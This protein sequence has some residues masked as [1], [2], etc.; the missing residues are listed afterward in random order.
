MGDEID[1]PDGE[2]I[3]IGGKIPPARIMTVELCYSDAEQKEH[4]LVYSKVIKGLTKS[5]D[6]DSLPSTLS[7]TQLFGRGPVNPGKLRRL[8]ALAFHGKLD[9][10]LSLEGISNK[11]IEHITDID[12]EGN[13][14]FELFWQLT[15]DGQ[16]NA[17]PR[18]RFDRARYLLCQSPR[19]KYLLKIFLAEGLT[20]SSAKPRF[21][22][23]CNW[24][25]TVWLV[26]MLLHALSLEFTS[27]SS[28]MGVA[29]RSE[30]I[31][32]FNDP[33]N[34]C[35]VFITTYTLGA[36]GLNLQNSCSRLVLME[37]AINYNRVFHAIGR[38][39]RLGQKEPQKIW[40]LFQDSTI[41]RWMEWR[42]LTKVRE[43]IAA[44][45]REAFE[46]ILKHRQEKRARDGISM[47]AKDEREGDIEDLC[48]RFFRDLMGQEEGCGDRSGMGNETE[49]DVV[50]K[51][52]RH[53]SRRHGRGINNMTRPARIEKRK[54]KE[55]EDNGEGPSTKRVAM[56]L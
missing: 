16:F 8:C 42:N 31:N 28:P 24:P 37:S 35:S 15:V 34:N 55:T 48:D 46:P 3:I 22:I 7:E 25:M 20:P 52:T 10:F 40:Y 45:N 56:P 27:I 17:P 33:N 11:Y 6:D 5:N 29:D 54:E 4:D 51:G 47:N 44:Q 2:K 38:M 9:A 36:F 49:L 13:M 19:L 30:A 12:K 23:F 39:H 1:M 43:Q 32:R 18:I 41:Q 53:H 21:V 26:Q 14:C 50:V